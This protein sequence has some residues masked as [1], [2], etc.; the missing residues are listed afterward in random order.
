[1]DLQNTLKKH[2]MQLK[3][4][5]RTLRS[6]VKVCKQIMATLYDTHFPS[7]AALRPG[8]KSRCPNSDILTIAWLLEI[9]G[10]ESELTGYKLIKAQLGTYSPICRNTLVS[11][12]ICGTCTTQAKN[13]PTLVRSF[14]GELQQNE[15]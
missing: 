12:G 4:K 7:V 11:I 9:T 14:I 8:P 3:N 5:P 6:V 13:S 1:M 10:K 2:V 15:R